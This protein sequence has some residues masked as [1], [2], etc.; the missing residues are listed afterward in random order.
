[1]VEGGDCPTLLCASPTSPR[2]LCAVLGTTVQKGCNTV[3]ECPEEDDEDGEGTRGEDVRRAAEVAW[4][5]P[6]GEEEAVGGPHHSIQL[7]SE[8][9]CR[10]RHSPV[11]RNHQ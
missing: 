9:E 10:G 1:M 7:P 5:V 2:A 3:G 11:L 6:P 4:P 8:G